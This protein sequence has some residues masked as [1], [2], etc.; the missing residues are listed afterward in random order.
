MRYSDDE[1]ER[2]N[3]DSSSRVDANGVRPFI[4][5]GDKEER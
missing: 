4:Y 5:R 3:V 1:L 2:L